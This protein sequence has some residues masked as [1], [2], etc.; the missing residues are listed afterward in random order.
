MMVFRISGAFSN[1]VIPVPIPNTEVKL[2]SAD[3]T[4]VLTL[5]K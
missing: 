3:D 2:I 4:W 1:N 5:G